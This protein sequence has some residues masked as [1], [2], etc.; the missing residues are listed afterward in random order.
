MKINYNMSAIIANNTLN[1]SENALSVSTERLSSGYKIN[2]AKDS[3]SGIAIAKKMNAQ[4]RGLSSAAQNSNDGI[5]VVETADGA[6]TEIHE[7]LQR[8]NE[9]GIKAAT[10]TVTDE[11]RESIQEEMSQLR[12]EI[13]RIARDTE[14]NGETLLDGSND[15]KGYVESS[16]HKAISVEYY[17]DAAEIGYYQAQVTLGTDAAGETVVTGATINNTP[18][19]SQLDNGKSV[20]WQT[21]ENVTSQVE[22][23]GCTVTLKGDNGFEMTLVIDVDNYTSNEPIDINLSGIGAMRIQV[24]A[25]EG[26]TMELRIPTVSAKTLGIE[27]ADMTTA[28]S[29]KKTIQKVESAISKLSSIRSRLGAYQNRLEHTVSSLEV[30]NENMTTAYS[31]IMDVNMATE[32]T[33]YTKNQVL[34]QAGTSMV[35]QANERPAQVLQLLQ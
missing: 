17:S 11:D 28:E 16:N 10:G 1:Q 30:T 15:L 24:G 22:D 27:D 33:E 35:A 4:I 13:E 8:I 14:F 32:M 9:L 6:L 2:H 26:Q 19:N 23:D 34:T 7:M 20:A 18:A 21:V 29:A 25:N 31:R 3:P 5:S 12:E